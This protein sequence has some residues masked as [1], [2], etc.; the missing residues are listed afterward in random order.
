MIL[1]WHLGELVGQSDERE[2][3]NIAVQSKIFNYKYKKRH[4]AMKS[5]QLVVFAGLITF[6]SCAS[7]PREASELSMELGNR[8]SSMEEA[9]I[10]LLNR[11][12][13]QKRSEIDNFIQNEW[14]P[15]FTDD[16]FSNPTITNAWDTIVAENNVADRREFILRLGPRMQQKI[17]EKRIELIQPVDQ[18]EHRIEQQLR[19]EYAQMRSI[20]NSI[21]S[22]LVSAAEVEDNR[23]QYLRMIGVSQGNIN[24]VINQTDTAVSNLLNI[25]NE[26]QNNVERSEEFI[27]TI[28]SI[29]I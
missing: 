23:N 24:Q 6:V 4:T 16:I 7:I 25:A 19:S 3:G 22:F 27:K 17:N 14:V 10:T 12:F 28:K 29:N 11:F 1:E 20:N 18:L 5:I 9:N 8:I 13:D 15:E 21:T 26:A 2:D